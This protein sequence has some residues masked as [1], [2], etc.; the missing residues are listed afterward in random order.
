[1]TRLE[2]DK[3]SPHR[4][5]QCMRKKDEE[6]RKCTQNLW[7]GNRQE[8]ERRVET[9][10]ATWAGGNACLYTSA[11]NIYFYASMEDIRACAMS[12]ATTCQTSE[13]P[14]R[15]MHACGCA[16][17]SRS[18]VAESPPACLSCQR[19]RYGVCREKSFQACCAVL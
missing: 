7:A 4:G 10:W 18:T 12:M 8:P 13:S 9:C 19:V 5:G 14:R 2:L 1:M 6:R 3:D 15:F 17:G 11:F 16:C